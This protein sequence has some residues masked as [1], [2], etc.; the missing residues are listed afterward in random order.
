MV[1]MIVVVIRMGIGL[2]S[3][4]RLLVDE[5][6]G[7]RDGLARLAVAGTG[8]PG[9]MGGTSRCGRVDAAVSELADEHLVP[10]AGDALLIIWKGA[11]GGL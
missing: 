3:A 10:F 9:G 11:C 2:V 4:H 1:M 6:V 8:A 5:E 7:D